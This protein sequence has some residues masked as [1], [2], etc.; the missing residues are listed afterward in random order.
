MPR[1]VHLRLAA[2]AARIASGVLALLLLAACEQSSD[3]DDDTGLDSSATKP[4][5]YRSDITEGLGVALDIV[6]DNSGSMA[7]AARG[8]K[9]PKYVVAREAIERMLDA[10]DS[11]VARRPDFP[12]LIALHVFSDDVRE[13]LPMQ[14]YNR[15]S[16]GAAL[17]RIR[18]PV[19]GTAIGL[20]IDAARKALYRSGVFRKNILVVTDGENTSGPNPGRIAR[21]VFERSEGG[22]RMYFVAFDV[23]AGKFSFVRAVRGE[24]IG[25]A[26]A[27][28]LGA[29]L[30]TL[31]QGRVLAEALDAG[32]GRVPP[33]SDSAAR[34]TPP[35]SGRDTSDHPLQ[36][37]RP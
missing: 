27:A 16:V 28:A 30:D 12:V 1:S 13:V 6:L 37:L 9:R 7:D 10:T 24:V 26:N 5:P 33:V 4:A 18:S 25:A 14:P 21:E 23:D 3:D 35:P 36:S 2:R 17:A 29:A 8:D 19:G 11:A 34:R 31:Y 15:D 20:G 22:V 32:E